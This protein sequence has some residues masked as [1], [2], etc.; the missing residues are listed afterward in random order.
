MLLGRRLD[1]TG[2]VRFLLI[3]IMAVGIWQ[4][5]AQAAAS[6]DFFP[7]RQTVRVG[8]YRMSGYH[9]IEPNGHRY[10]YGYDYLHLIGRYTDWRYEYIGY[11]QG[12]L[13]MFALLDAGQ[14]DLITAAQ[15]TPER[16]AKYIFSDKPMAYS[17]L[18]MTTLETNE[19]YQPGRP[20][21]Y[22]GMR[23][24]LLKGNM[25]SV[26]FGKFAEENGFSY[27]PVYY[28]SVTAEEE[29][30]KS[31]EVDAIV[32]SSKRILHGEK[33]LE[34]RSPTPLY[35]L[36]TPDK[37]DIIK[38]LNIA[39]YKLSSLDPGW[40][41]AL[42]SRYYAEVSGRMMALSPDSQAFL[43]ELKDSGHVFRVVVMPNANP[44]AYFDKNGQ[45][46]GILPDIFALLAQTAGIRYEILS[47][48]NQD[49]YEQ[50][51][52]DKNTDIV[53]GMSS[54]FYEAEKV[55][56]KL[57]QAVLRS[58]IVQLSLKNEEA[59]GPI[60][61]TANLKR[62]LAMVGR[63]P[64]NADQQNYD[65]P[66]E[67]MAA[68]KAGKCSSVYMLG[69][70]GEK[71]V[72][73][74]K[75]NNLRISIV[76]NQQLDMRLGIRDAYDHRLFEVLSAA[77]PPV[78]SQAVQEIIYRHTAVH[79]RELSWEEMVYSYPLQFI[80]LAILLFML[81]GLVMVTLVRNNAARQDEKR[82]QEVD[83]VM[84]YVCRMHEMVVKVDLRTGTA[85]EYHIDQDGR[86]FVDILPHTLERYINYLHPADREKFLEGGAY[87]N[88]MHTAFKEKRIYYCE[89]RKQTEDNDYRFFSCRFQPYFQNGEL[90][91]FYFYRQDIDDERRKEISQRE[92]LSDALKTARHAS[93]AKG[94]F[95]SRMS[96]EIRTPLNAI[97][98]YLTLGAQKNN[99]EEDLRQVIGKSQIAA[100]H[101]L[102]L[103]NDI[104]DL[105]S[106]EQ[107][108]LQ[109]AQE[110]FSL[111]DMVTE[112]QTIFNGQLQQKNITLI[113]DEQGVQHFC[114][115]GDSLRIKQVLMNIF[116]NAVKFT[117]EGGTISLVMKQILRPN[118]VFI[119]TFEITDSGIGM[120]KEYLENIF[121]PFEQE[122][123][124]VARRYG[125]SGLG[126]AISQNLV[127]MM[128]G[129]IEVR[130]TQGVGTSFYVSLPLQGVKELTEEAEEKSAEV[131]SFVGVRLLLV[132]DNEMNREISETILEQHGFV[133]DTAV[134]GQDAVDK[135]TAAA[136]G[137][138]KA[139]LMDV[140]MPVLDGY[141]ATKAIRRSSHPEAASIPIIAVTADVFTDDV[142]RAM[143]CG[144][145]DYLSKPIDFDKLLEKLRKFM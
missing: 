79:A 8:F 145:N 137:T 105:S 34:L 119:T 43:Q 115:K 77:M 50:L 122:S 67:A 111:K 78:G 14:I 93:E 141:G 133:I 52:R 99:T 108:K 94:E 129:F 103:I 116:S 26:E 66:E 28:E 109:L 65:T 45:A 127:K 125:G 11:D 142:A 112:I 68:L 87:D 101:L 136:A 7:K 143:A 92:A 41:V 44:Y 46:Q 91:G 117:P 95:L 72:N 5:P 55:G 100:H 3:F 13:D 70:I 83:A 19:K 39:Q 89:V 27:T 59:E 120:S 135:F 54:N 30:L 88:E 118:N 57:T 139:I 22:A 38:D 69:F 81:A 56:Y 134:D 35:A 10:G 131:I 60:A 20:D 107:G 90:V 73:A 97:I 31:G 15:K 48:A 24:G 37:Q 106:I 80:L 51:L 126:L 132:E 102:A 138:Y 42:S 58:S 75:H 1:I 16:A 53:L 86:V 63:L 47:A 25:R 2:I 33:I 17:S 123:A 49:E 29:G 114:L 64:E 84:S 62:K 140:Q 12:W 76:P 96:H 144:M 23:V 82:R 113:I 9:E 85:T 124:K 74:D 128:Q 18:M 40:E 32:T 61:M 104:L 98:G 110:E 36:S 130:S 21:T 71:Y 121:K 6:M 4:L